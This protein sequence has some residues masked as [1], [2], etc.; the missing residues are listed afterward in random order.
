MPSSPADR[1]DRLLQTQKFAHLEWSG[2][3]GDVNRRFPLDFLLAARALFGSR[4]LRF[5]PVGEHHVCDQVERGRRFGRVL[6]HDAINSLCLMR[7]PAQAHTKLSRRSIVI[8]LRLPSLCR[9]VNSLT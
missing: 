8:R 2:L 5:W 1:A 3:G 7:R 9:R 4:T 6:C